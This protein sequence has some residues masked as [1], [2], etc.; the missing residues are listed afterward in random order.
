[1]T[2]NAAELEWSVI[3]PAYN[4]EGRLGQTLER[5]VD[6]LTAAG[7]SF[8][9]IVVDDGSQDRTCAVAEEG[10][11]EVPHMVVRNDPNRGKG[12]SVRRGMLLGQGRYLLFTDADLATPIEEIRPLRAALDAGYDIAIASR[13]L[14]A[15]S[16]EVHESWLRETLGK[17]FNL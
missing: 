13:G 14:A 4:E 17:T 15:S 11:Q 1:M 16:I 5:I 2:T 8:E 7:E 10:L 9:I 6:Y 12:Y 3:V